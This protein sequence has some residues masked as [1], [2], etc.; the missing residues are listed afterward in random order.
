[1]TNDEY[2]T[3]KKPFH[4]YSVIFRQ[5]LEG[6]GQVAEAK[7]SK[8]Q[9]SVTVTAVDSYDAI[10]VVCRGWN[11]KPINIVDVRQCDGKPTRNDHLD[12]VE[13]SEP[14]NGAK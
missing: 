6:E 12:G 9:R 1:M 13:F 4:T 2:L 8:R 3:R 11:I 10:A 7:S 5:K 14:K